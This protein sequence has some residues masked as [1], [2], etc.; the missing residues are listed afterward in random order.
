MVIDASLMEF[1]EMTQST[2][3]PD[4]YAIMKGG[5][6]VALMM[7]LARSAAHIP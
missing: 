5:H 7:S 3:D 1:W 2:L 4:C 6:W